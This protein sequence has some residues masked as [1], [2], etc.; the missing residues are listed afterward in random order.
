MAANCFAADGGRWRMRMFSPAYGVVEDAATGS[1]AGPLAIHLA[2]HG[3]ATFGRRVEIAQG[4]EMGRSA[5]MLATAHGSG[6]RLDRVEVGGPS[7]IVA[8]GTFHV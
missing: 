7:V 8:H 5:R 4:V 1:A 2:R 3:P 6:A